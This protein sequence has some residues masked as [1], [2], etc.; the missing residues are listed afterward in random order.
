MFLP[1]PRSGFFRSQIPDPDPGVKKA[2][3][4]GCVEQNFKF[5]GN[6]NKIKFGKVYL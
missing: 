4:P 6:K 2:E 3:D 5:N 1:D